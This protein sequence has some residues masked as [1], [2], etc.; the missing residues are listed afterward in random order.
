MAVRGRSGVR[1]REQKPGVRKWVRELGRS[2][3]AGIVIEL[4]A[5][6]LLVAAACL[7]ALVVTGGRL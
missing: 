7:V 3:L 1:W 6:M 5:V 2:H 4:H